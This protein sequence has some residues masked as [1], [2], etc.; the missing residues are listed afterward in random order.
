MGIE[1]KNGMNLRRILVLVGK[2]FR[3]GSKNFILVFAFVV[4]ILL[5]LVISLLF[6]TLFSGKPKLGITDQGSSQL[7]A[8]LVE[9]Q[10]LLTKQYTSEQDLKTAVESGGVDFGIVIPANFDHDLQKNGKP[11]IDAYLWGESLL[12]N[13]AAIATTLIVLVRE[14]VG[15]EIP[16]Q[17]LTT[18]LGDGNDIPW[19]T[20]LFPFIVFMAIFLGGAMVPATSLVEEKQKR[21]IKALVI[22]PTTYYDVYLAKGIFG[23]LVSIFVALLVL[24]LN[25]AFGSQPVL[26]TS[27]LALSAVMAAAIGILLGAFIKDI[28]TLFAVIKGMGLLLY[29]PLFVYLFPTIPQWIG[30]IFPT[31]YMIGPIME[32]SQRDATWSQVAVDIYILIGLILFLFGALYWVARRETARAV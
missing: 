22:T 24:L 2:E 23:F 25:R 13:R 9:E 18:S 27:V 3:Y 17:I 21:T 31:Y 5:S 14:M 11:E 20:R 19:E 10:A 7:S 28:N 1:E 32:I 8:L 26:L 15:Q 30:R 29:A 12:K 16:V 4:P 6:G